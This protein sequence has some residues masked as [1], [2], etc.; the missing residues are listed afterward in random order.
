MTVLFLAQD[1]EVPD[2]VWIEH[3]RVAMPDEDIVGWPIPAERWPDVDA[4]VV[5]NPPPGVLPEFPN[6]KLIQCLWA[7]VDGLL[8]DPTLPPQ[9]PVARLVD[10]RM[11]ETMAEAVLTAVLALHR[12]LPFYVR[13]QQQKV[14]A[15]QPY[16]RA[17]H[18]RVG[19]LG[20]GKMG[21][22]ACWALLPQEFDLR[23]WRRRATGAEIVPIHEGPDGHFLVAAE[24]DI[25]VNL[26]PLTDDTRGILNATLF[27]AMPEGAALINFGRGGHVVEADLLAALDAGRLSHAMLDV[28][29][30]EP[31]P[32]DHPFWTH[33]GVTVTPHVAAQTDVRT[34]AALAAKAVA[35]LRAGQPI[36]HLVD[37][38]AGY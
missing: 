10:P 24:S 23:A 22:A 28:F 25:L 13:Q 21:E 33:S 37:R 18:R 11:A 3:L 36:P 35:A 4:A 1:P 30:T 26:L 32:E 19:I 20:Y 14:W 5:A 6:L 29:A 9:V 27:A 7:G 38:T 17:K 16:A 34:G 12:G 2:A 31:L 8:A 15:K